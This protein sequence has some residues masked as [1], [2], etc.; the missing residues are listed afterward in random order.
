MLYDTRW[1]DNL[2]KE[3]VLAFKKLSRKKGEQLIQKMNQWLLEHDRDT[4]EE[5]EGDGRYRAGLGLYYFEEK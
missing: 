4:A 3:S 1:Y 5:V 2:P